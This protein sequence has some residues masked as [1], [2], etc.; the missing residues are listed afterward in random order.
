MTELERAIA[1]TV[2]RA[3]QARLEPKT[4]CLKPDDFH[5]LERLGHGEEI[6]GLA[7][8]RRAGKG[9]GSR[10]YCRGG[11]AL[12]VTSRPARPLRPY[13][14]AAAAASAE[15]PSPPASRRSDTRR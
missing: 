9:Q 8:K 12:A 1:D 15:R 10:L 5:A 14:R 6:G 11:I 7:I 2:A 3:V 13:A 4:L